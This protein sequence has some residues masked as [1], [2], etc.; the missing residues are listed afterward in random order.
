MNIVTRVNGKRSW[1]SGTDSETNSRMCSACVLLNP[2]SQGYK[3]H[4]WL[5]GG[6]RLR[7]VGK[8]ETESW[9]LAGSIE[10]PQTSD[11]TGSRTD[12]VQKCDV[13]SKK[14]TDESSCAPIG[15]GAKSRQLENN[16]DCSGEEVAVEL[17]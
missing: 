5:K 10:W 2:K 13:C 8:G 3:G 4:P 1:A 11:L 15:T 14:R 9:A 12:E 7:A 17:W 16:L 6:S